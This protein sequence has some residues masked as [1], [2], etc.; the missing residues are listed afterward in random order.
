[1]K[2][3]KTRIITF[4]VPKEIAKIRQEKLKKIAKKKGKDR[5]VSEKSLALCHWSIFVTNCDEKLLSG[6]MIRSVYRIRW[7]I[8][9]IFKTWKSILKIDECNAIANVNRFKCELYGKFILAVL[10]TNI[11]VKRQLFFPLNDN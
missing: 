9:L 8:E 3:H 11:Y 6:K 4:R 10:I 2:K 7:T 5:E 1:M